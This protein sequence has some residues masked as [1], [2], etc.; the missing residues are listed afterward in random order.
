MDVLCSGQFSFV[1]GNFLSQCF[2]DVV[3]F[4]VVFLFSL[5][6]MVLS[7][8][9][10]RVSPPSWLFFVSGLCGLLLPLAEGFALLWSSHLLSGGSVLRLVLT[11]ACLMVSLLSASSSST[12]LAFVCLVLLFCATALVLQL[13]LHA[14]SSVLVGFRLASLGVLLVQ[15]VALWY[16][17]ETASS[18]SAEDPKVR[19][20]IQEIDSI[21]HDGSDDLALFPSNKE[22]VVSP[23]ESASIPSRVVF[24][25][26]TPLIVSAS[27]GPLKEEHVW[28]LLACDKAKELNAVVDSLG[29]VSVKK[30]LWALFGTE[31]LM[32]GLYKII[33]DV[34]VFTGP[35]F[36]TLVL[37]FLQHKDWPLWIGV[38]ISFGIFLGSVTQTF[39]INA[40]FLRLSRVAVQS[41]SVL[42]SLILRHLFVS[43]APSLGAVATLV[44]VDA[45]RLLN[46]VN[47]LHM[48]WSA[49]LQVMR[50]EKFVFILVLILSQDW[51]RGLPS[52][53]STRSCYVCWAWSDC[54]NVAFQLLDCEPAVKGSSLFAWLQ[55]FEN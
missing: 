14:G 26:A 29:R 55:R 15:N 49:P 17:M 6:G 30:A 53:Q 4:P 20:N 11:S 45:G 22:M 23:E 5:L 37:F 48:V 12:W 31:F 32:A 51:W 33:N 47:Y 18:S 40:Y 46:S 10:S 24:S 7:F 42:T 43:R 3:V 34:C 9:C 54:C 16:H 44:S 19:H 25:W 39:A 41:R 27:N 35:L 1:S 36:L 50:L 38:S 28:P 13:D 52:L 21:L 2:L 8:K